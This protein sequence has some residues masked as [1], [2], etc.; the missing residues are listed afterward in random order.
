MFALIAEG[1]RP[2]E[3]VQMLRSATVWLGHYPRKAPIGVICPVGR[4]HDVL[5]LKLAHRGQ[6]T[7]FA[8][9]SRTQAHGFPNPSIARAVAR[10]PHEI[11]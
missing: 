5:Q 7:V 11:G 9:I 4:W 10:L 1:T 3:V 8:G 6:E 2:R